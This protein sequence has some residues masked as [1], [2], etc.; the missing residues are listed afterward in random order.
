M[1]KGMATIMGTAVLNVVS[2]DELQ[3]KDQIDGFG[4]E[5]EE[6]L[7]LLRINSVF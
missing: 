5:N 7:V 4:G 2:E 6:E 3:I 1:P